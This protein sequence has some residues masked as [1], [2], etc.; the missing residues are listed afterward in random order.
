[1]VTA[2]V[3]KDRTIQSTKFYLLETSRKMNDMDMFSISSLVS[4]Q[5][6]DSVGIVG[7]TCE[8]LEDLVSQMFG[9]YHRPPSPRSV[10]CLAATHGLARLTQ[11]RQ[12]STL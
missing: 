5:Y 4:V 10:K 6:V 1:M 7:R 3:E 8:E 9:L 2:L 12:I 11:S